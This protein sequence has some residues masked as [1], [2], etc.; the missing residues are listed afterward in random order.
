MSERK[1]V[2]VRDVMN[3]RFILADG[4]ETVGAAFSELKRREARCIL[5]KKRTDK[6]EY[7]MVLLSDIAK[8]V[9]VPDR[10]PDRVNIYEIV[11]KPVISVRPEM[12]IRYTARLFSQFGLSVAPVV[13]HDQIVGVVTYNDMVLEGLQVGG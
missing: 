13:D 1:V 9:F 11:S 3:D 6:D 7:G 8:K 10:S 5:V 12:D 4:L 2:H